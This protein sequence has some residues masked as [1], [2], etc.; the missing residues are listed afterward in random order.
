M[1]RRSAAEVAA[2]AAELE[3]ITAV[4]I[5]RWELERRHA[6]AAKAAETPESRA[7][8]AAL[9]LARKVR[10]LVVDL[11]E[12]QRYA[13]ALRMLEAVPIVVDIAMREA[14]RLRQLLASNLEKVRT[15]A[16]GGC[17]VS[18]ALLLQIEG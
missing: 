16:A 9:A 3:G 7:R 8:K 6:A 12:A 14:D 17:E 13:E 11:D 18:K 10:R 4:V 5:E 1:L 15:L 2:H